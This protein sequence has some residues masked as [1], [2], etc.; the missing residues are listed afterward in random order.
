MIDNFFSTN[1][2]A[3]LIS[4]LLGI[5]VL[6]LGRKLFW[7]ATAAV[8]FILG[9]T[10]AA[11]GLTDQ[12]DWLTLLIALLAGGVGALLAIF[13]Q[14]LAVGLAGLVLG[15][16]TIIVL[17]DIFGLGLAEW[18]W[19]LIIGGGILGIILAL[20]L[21]EPALIILSVLA[22]AILIIQAT[23]FSPLVSGLLFLI[24]LVVGLTVQMRM[25]ADP[26]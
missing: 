16:Y 11:Q 1:A 17:L 7:L 10:L 26:S 22:G 20:S 19:L 14:K 4:L 5:A 21:L 18:A 15:G 12:P 9:L 24:L 25:L 3:Q 13:V 8:G 6:T 23:N 2:G